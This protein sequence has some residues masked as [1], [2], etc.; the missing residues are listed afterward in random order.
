MKRCHRV[1]AVLM[2]AATP[3][4]F[5]GCYEHVVRAEGA[6]GRNAQIHEPAL[7]DERTIV[8]DLEDVIMGPKR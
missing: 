3:C 2:I 1:V 5:S 8:D 7:K 4:I 6:A